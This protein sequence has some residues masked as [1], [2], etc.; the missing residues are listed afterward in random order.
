VFFE[1]YVARHQRSEKDMMITKILANVNMFCASQCFCNPGF[2]ALISE[3]IAIVMDIIER[4]NRTKFFA[5][6]DL[7]DSHGTHEV[8]LNLILR[9]WENSRLKLI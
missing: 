3:D 4:S 6:G 1:A 8:C 2:F 5:A 7:G 9:Q